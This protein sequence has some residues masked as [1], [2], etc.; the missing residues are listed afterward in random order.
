MKQALLAAAGAALILLATVGAPRGRSAAVAE[1]YP[2][3]VGFSWT[4]RGVGNVTVVRRVER[5]VE[6]DG[7]QYFEMSYVLPFLGTRVLPMRRVEGGVVTCREGREFL[8]LK[9]PM[10]KGD[11]WTID[12]PGEKETADCTVTGEEPIEFA[13]RK[14]VATRLEVVRRKRESTESSTDFEWYVPGVGLAKMQ[15]T[16]GIQATFVLER[17]EKAD[18]N[19]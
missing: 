17:F 7:R 8:L 3:D 9:F 14:A 16:L 10:L 2:L 19:R 11:R 15:V 12:L 1:L 13:G 6:I 4:Y 5:A 18:E